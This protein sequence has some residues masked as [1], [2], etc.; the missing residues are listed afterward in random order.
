MKR[1][2][3]LVEIN[4]VEYVK[5]KY[6]KLDEFEDK[7]QYRRDFLKEEKYSFDLKNLEE[8]VEG[9][10]I[11]DIKDDYVKIELINLSE[12]ITRVDYNSVEI[13]KGK[14]IDLFPRMGSVVLTKQNG[15]NRC[16]I[17]ISLTKIRD[18]E[19]VINTY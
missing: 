18:V 8:D 6:N 14:S 2:S 3:F 7:R 15:E 5:N 12:D 11:K 13:E 17:I 19:A 9:F 4:K 1:A 16:Q 10:K